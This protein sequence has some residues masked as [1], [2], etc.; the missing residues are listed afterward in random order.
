M[1]TPMR[2]SIWTL[3]AL[4]ALA[5]CGGSKTSATPDAAPDGGTEPGGSLMGVVGF[6]GDEYYE[7]DQ[8]FLGDNGS[9]VEPMPDGSLVVA[10]SF[11]QQVTLGK[12]GPNETT[13][14]AAGGPRDADMFLAK[15]NK[16][17]TLVWAV[18]A[19]GAESCDPMTEVCEDAA[20]GLAAF[21]DGSIVVAGQ[22]EQGAVFGEG[23]PNETTIDGKGA[24]L[25]KYEED[26]SLA[27]ANPFE[28]TCGVE[29]WAQTPCATAALE[30]GSFLVTSIFHDTVTLGK[31]QPNETTLTAT[32][33]PSGETG[34]DLFLAKYDSKGA[35]VWASK[36]GGETSETVWDVATNGSNAIYWLG[37]FQFEGVQQYPDPGAMTFGEG[38][39]NETSFE[40][41]G[42]T[43]F[44]TSLGFLARYGLDGKLAWAVR[45]ENGCTG[46]NEGNQV[47]VLG[48]GSPLISCFS[49]QVGMGGEPVDAV[50]DPGGPNELRVRGPFI[51]KY[52]ANGTPV[53][54]RPA[55]AASSDVG[56]WAYGMAVAADDSF[57]LT[58][59]FRDKTTWGAGQPEKTTL[60]PTSCDF[61][62]CS[63]AFVAKF[64]AQGDL[65]WVVQAG[66]SGILHGGDQD[67]GNDVAVLADGS[68]AVI[69]EYYGTATFGQGEPNETKVTADGLYDIFVMRLAQ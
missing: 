66:G 68:I 40:Y 28:G 10:G 43:G 19:G 53:W 13:L 65:D 1:K 54:A 5:G 51:A 4:A 17:L 49:E 29:K 22:F 11:A 39:P 44:D 25:A 38:E 64:T 52:D 56:A 45:I 69:G 27:W 60:V 50:F 55:F 30:D 58:G 8:W 26:G 67:R 3:I 63:D 62:L 21:P 12:G 59:S 33:Y 14:V 24:F 37:Q 15:Y 41:E 32:P 57:V 47:V 7:G 18:R 36:A 61:D 35:L 2:R 23:E 9:S 34:S 6:G 46:S 42:T 20:G 16:D 31:G 48:D